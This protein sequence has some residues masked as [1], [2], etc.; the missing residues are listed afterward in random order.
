MPAVMGLFQSTEQAE[1]AVVELS[2][3]GFTEKDV[4]LVLFSALPSK[5]P[6]G[7]LEWLS[8]GGALGD[9]IDKSDGVSVM[10]GIGIGAVFGGLLGITL[11][12]RWHLG[13]VVWATLGMLGGG[14]LGLLVDRLIP[15][16]RRD[17]LE[18]SLIAGL[19]LL[20]VSSPVAERLELARRIL[21]G[22]HVKQMADLPDSEAA[23]VL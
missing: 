4:A 1:R 20:Q 3:N 21:K 23:K 22:A 9:T 17:Q 16:K 12:S 15:E 13:P 19:I 18:S 8:R 2:L 11:G 10:D 5:K 14:M 6:R 7:L